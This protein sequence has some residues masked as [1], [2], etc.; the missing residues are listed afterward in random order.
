MVG[1]EEE[2]RCCVKEVGGKGKGK[3]WRERVYCPD[4]LSHLWVWER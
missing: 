1:D 2:E 4:G 3:E